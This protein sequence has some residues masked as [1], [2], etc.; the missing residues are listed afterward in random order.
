MTYITEQNG[1]LIHKI[2]EKVLDTI[3]VPDHKMDAVFEVVSAI[4]DSR[5]HS[6]FSIT[7]SEESMHHFYELARRVRCFM[8]QRGLSD[9]E[10]FNHTLG[11]LQQM[12]RESPKNCEAQHERSRAVQALMQ[13]AMNMAIAMSHT[14]T[15]RREL[16]KRFGQAPAH[17]PTAHQ[18]MAG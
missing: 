6:L 8:V 16:D 3:I 18:P 13:D 17:Q 2:A 7:V 12:E 4:E 9:L 10:T 15:G 5:C 11:E 14:S 1:H